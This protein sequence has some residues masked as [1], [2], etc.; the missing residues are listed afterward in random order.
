MGCTDSKEA[1]KKQAA[2]PAKVETQAPKEPDVPMPGIVDVPQDETLKKVHL[3]IDLFESR[4]GFHETFESGR[5]LYLEGIE[6]AMYGEEEELPT[7]HDAA[8]DDSNFVEILDKFT[9]EGATVLLSQHKEHLNHLLEQPYP[10]A[11]IQKWDQTAW[12]AKKNRAMEVWT[13]TQARCLVLEWF[14][15]L[16]RREWFKVNAKTPLDD[17]HVV[18]FPLS[19]RSAAKAKRKRVPSVRGN[20]VVIKKDMLSLVVKRVQS[21]HPTHLVYVYNATT[22]QQVTLHAGFGDESKATS[23]SDSVTQEPDGQFGIVVM[24]QETIPYVHGSFPKG[25]TSLDATPQYDEINNFDAMLSRAKAAQVFIV[26]SIEAM[27][28]AV[29]EARFDADPMVGSS[30]EVDKIF[31]QCIEK[32]TP[33]IDPFFPPLHSSLNLGDSPW[34]W[35]RPFQLLDGNRG[36]LNLDK[37]IPSDIDEGGLGDGWFVC[38]IVILCERPNELIHPIFSL[39]ASYPKKREEQSNGGYRLKLCKEG[40]W[41][42]VLI[43]DYLPAMGKLPSFARNNNPSELWTSLLQKAYA[44]LHGSYAA[45]KLGD[46]CDALSDLTGY[47]VTKLN[48]EGELRENEWPALLELIGKNGLLFFSTQ[49]IE[50]QAMS[51][52]MDVVQAFA[53][54]GLAAGYSFAV[55]QLKEI[56]I[57]NEVVQLVQL[58]NQ[59]GNVSEWNGDWSSKSYLWQKHPDI[60]KACKFSPDDD[61]VFWMQYSDCLKWFAS[62]GF[63]NIPQNPAN[64]T[65]IR[66]KGNLQHESG[67]LDFVIKL[68]IQVATTLFIS[69]HQES[70]REASDPMHPTKFMAAVRYAVIKETQ[71]QGKME[72]VQFTY[73]QVD[74]ESKE[75]DGVFSPSANVSCGVSLQP[76]TYY[77]VPEGCNSVETVEYNKTRPLVVSLVS[78][79][80]NVGKATTLSTTEA[81]TNSLELVDFWGFLDTPPTPTTAKSVQLN[82]TTLPFPQAE[83][84]I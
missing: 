58:R 19:A 8:V 79:Q 60:A 69:L 38:A 4:S 17:T 43:D 57:N 13:R 55:L 66:W 39:P 53:E 63:L 48:Q 59:W 80:R 35:K 65:D 54:V 76:G 26:K 72:V 68:D 73:E 42:E 33:F 70:G 28:A 64:V 15:S 74:A 30:G 29:P 78:T 77:L 24:P 67:L 83:I 16:G 61:D 50:V 84:P 25:L 34:P 23:A 9:T 41:S 5:Q 21:K 82:G 46:T 2:A 12:N 20:E 52:S 62:C 47:P 75:K 1:N 31:Q 45:I 51:R 22:S 7:Y 37:I 36:T 81:M 11:Q 6:S 44:K 27:Q 56:M 40:W 71:E 18:K 10:A 3:N 32:T 14:E 49:G